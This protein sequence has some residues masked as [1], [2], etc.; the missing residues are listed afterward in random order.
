MDIWPSS[1]VNTFRDT[2]FAVGRLRE[3]T[4]YGPVQPTSRTVSFG[5]DI[6]V[7]MD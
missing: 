2:R 6:V 5:T 3:S 7:K 4:G 1:G